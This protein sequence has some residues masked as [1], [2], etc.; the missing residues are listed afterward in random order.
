LNL[1]TFFT[2][3]TYRTMMGH[4]R[5]LTLAILLDIALSQ[6]TI[7]AASTTT[8]N[9][10]I[11]SLPI[12]LDVTSGGDY[13]VGPQATYLSPTSTI[14]FASGT[15][16]FRAS[17]VINGTITTILTSVG[18]TKTANGTSTGTSTSS[19]PVNTQPCNG[20]PEFCTRPYSNITMVAAH[21]FA[22]VQESSFA[23]NQE[24]D[25]LNQL[26]DGIR[27]RECHA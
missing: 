17:G 13:A 1:T 6:S 27:M 7:S 23:A 20:H 3:V 22:F 2:Q 5:W 25:V 4:A 21:N 8:L 9:K 10:S 14:L 11:L 12:S 26:K 24:L 15:S 16:I 18:G 19:A